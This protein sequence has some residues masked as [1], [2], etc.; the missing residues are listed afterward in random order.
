MKRPNMNASIVNSTRVL[1][2]AALTALVSACATSFPSTVSFPSAIAELDKVQPEAPHLDIQSWQTDQGA[3]VLFVASDALPMLDIRLVAHAGGA[4]DGGQ[5]GLAALTSA[6]LGKGAT[7]LSVEE[8]ARGFED[9]G[10]VFSTGS[11]RDMGVI[12]LRT[13]TR[14]Q[15]RQASIDMLVRVI[16]QPTF[17]SQALDTWC[18]GNTSLPVREGATMACSAAT[19]PSPL[20]P[21][22]TPAFPWR[23]WKKH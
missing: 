14:P 19:A 22:R 15:W 1:V 6:L 20:P 9:H 11:Y 18:A 17:P 3:R 4:H 12:S 5:P 23:N 2:L 8:I 7:G 21:R 10:A 13:L 16:G